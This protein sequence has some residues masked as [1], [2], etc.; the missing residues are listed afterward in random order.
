M[1]KTLEKNLN[2]TLK[3]ARENISYVWLMLLS[4]IKCINYVFLLN[5]TQYTGTTFKSAVVKNF[6]P[7][8]AESW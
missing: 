1:V 7:T 2:I 3:L 6:E 8:I 4:Y 5:T